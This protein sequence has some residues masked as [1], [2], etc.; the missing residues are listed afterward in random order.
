MEVKL[1]SHPACSNCSPIISIVAF[2]RRLNF[3][4]SIEYLVS[5]ELDKCSIPAVNSYPSR[6]DELWCHTCFEAFMCFE[7]AEGYYELNISPTED[8]NFYSFAGYHK[9]RSTE[10]RVDAIHQESQLYQ[11]SFRKVVEFDIRKIFPDITDEQSL[12]LNVTAVIEDRNQN[13]SYW[14]HTH[15]NASRPD[16]HLREGFSIRL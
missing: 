5:G 13:L 11:N 3:N 9:D 12:F 15:C 2:L 14:A 7:N 6:V 10:Y 1:Q 8:W 4:I 16:F